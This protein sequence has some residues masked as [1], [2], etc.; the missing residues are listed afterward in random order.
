MTVAYI[1]NGT[2]YN[3]S[4]KNLDRFLQD[5]PNAKKEEDNTADNQI[6]KYYNLE[7]NNWKSYN[8]SAKNLERFKQDYPE[9]RTQQGW[10]DYANEIKTNQ[11]QQKIEDQ[12]IEDDKKKAFEDH[13]NETFKTAFTESGEDFDPSFYNNIE[14]KEKWLKDNDYVL[15]EAGDKAGTY[16]K[17]ETI[18]GAE[19]FLD[20]LGNTLSATG[21]V[22]TKYFGD[23]DATL[24]EAFEEGSE[25]LK[26]YE[27]ETKKEYLLRENPNYLK[28]TDNKISEQIAALNKQK[29]LE[30]DAA[31]IEKIN[32]QIAQ[33]NDS[34]PDIVE[35]S[36]QQVT[37]VQVED[38]DD[39]A[40]ELTNQGVF[41][42]GE[43]NPEI[44]R[45]KFDSL[46]TD[47]SNWPIFEEYVKILQAEQRIFDVAGDMMGGG[48]PEGW[49]EDAAKIAAEFGLNQEDVEKA[50]GS[51]LTF[52]QKGLRGFSLSSVTV[53]DLFKDKREELI[54]QYD[55]SLVDK[56]FEKN[57]WLDDEY[58]KIIYPD[59]TDDDVV[60]IVQGEKLKAKISKA[61]ITQF[62]QF[63][64]IPAIE[65]MTKKRTGLETKE[66]DLQRQEIRNMI[67]QGFMSAVGDDAV[68]RGILDEYVEEAKP[69]L[70]DYKK[71][72]LEQY[73]MTNADDVMKVNRLLEQKQNELTI[74]KMVMDPRYRNR[75]TNIGMAFAEIG[76]E[77][78]VDFTRQQSW[79]Q[80]N[81]DRI[82]DRKDYDWYNPLEFIAEVAEGIGSGVE[83]MSTAIGDQ[84]VASFDGF[85]SREKVKKLDKI[86]EALKQEGVNED[87]YIYFDVWGDAHVVP[88]EDYDDFTDFFT[89]DQ[90]Y[91]LSAE[92]ISDYKKTLNEKKN[93]WDEGISKQMEEAAKSMKRLDAYTSADY[94]DGISLRDIAS[95]VG[96]T[97]PHI[98]VAAAGTIV[99]G[100]AGLP[101]LLAGE[102]SIAATLA[103]YGGTLTMGLQMYG[104]NY[105]SAIEQ[106]LKANKQ[107]RESI[108]EE[109][110]DWTE[111]QVEEQ[112]KQNLI[113]NYKSGEGANI[114]QS[115]AVGAMQ[116]ALES[117]G[118]Q[119]MVTGLQGALKA[120]GMTELTLAS[121]ANA[122]WDDIGKGLYAYAINRGGNALEEFGTE[123][124]QEVLGMMSTG[125]QR[126]E[127]LGTYVN[128]EEALQSGVGGAISGFAI[129]FSGDI[130][131]MSTTAIRQSAAAIAE[132]YGGD[133]KYAQKVKVANAWFNDS[134]AQLDKA[135]DTNEID[136]KKYNESVRALSN[137][138][139]AAIKIGLFGNTGASSTTMSRADKMQLLDLYTDIGTLEQEIEL[140]KDNVPLQNALKEELKVLQSAATDLIIA[141]RVAAK[142]AAADRLAERQQSVGMSILPT[143]TTEDTDS[144]SKIDEM[145]ADEDFD[146]EN[147]LDQKRILK[148]AGG[149]INNAL[150]RLWKPGSLLTRDQFKTALENEYLKT[151]LSYNPEQDTNNQGI[152]QQT[153]NLFN[154]RANKIAKENIRQ[155]GDTISMSDEKAP[156]IGDTTQQQDFDAETQEVRGKR[157]KKYLGSNEK[158]NEA[159]GPEAK[160]EIKNQTSQEILN[161][162][163]K[164]STVSQIKSAINNMFGD[165]KSRGGR[166][167]WKTLGNKIGT[168]TKGY[169]NFVDSVVD[170]E[171]ISQLPAAYIKQSGLGKLLGV[172]KIGKSDKV[173]EKD[174]KKTYSRPDTF[175]LPGEITPEMVQKV[176][177][178]FK[179]DN[180]S[181]IR[182]MQKMSQEFAME[183]L[184][185][186]K[187]DKD[188]M[189]KLQTALGDTQTAKDFMN[190]LESKMDQR[191]VEDSTLDVTTPGKA[192]EQAIDDIVKD[193]N[194]K[195]KDVLDKAIEYFEGLDD[196]FKNT[197]GANPITPFIKAIKLGLKGLR[198]LL[199]QGATL[200]QAIVHAKNVFKNA[201]KYP[202]KL[203]SALGRSARLEMKDLVASKNI[204]LFNPGRKGNINKEQQR[205]RRIGTI[206]SHFL[207]GPEFITSSVLSGSNN[208]LY[209]VISDAEADINSEI[210][211]DMAAELRKQGVPLIELDNGNFKYD[212]RQAAKIDKNGI[213]TKAANEQLGPNSYKTWSPQKI[214][215]KINDPNWRQLQK[216]KLKLL[217]RIAK[218]I[219]TDI[220]ANPQNI[221][222]WASWLTSQSSQSRH[223]I[224][225]LAPIT[226]FNLSKGAPSLFVAEHSLPANN[227]AT[228]IMDMAMRGKVDSEFKLIEKDY[229]QGKLLEA[230]DNKLKTNADKIL[231]SKDM[232]SIYFTGPAMTLNPKTWL[233]YLD[234]IVNDNK[235]GINMNE[236]VTFNND[237]K[238]I[239]VAE[240]FGLPLTKSEYRYGNNKTNFG[241]IKFQNE[242]LYK[243]AAGDMN[244]RQ[245]KSL[246]KTAV[247]SGVK[248][249]E[250][251]MVDNNTD[252]FGSIFRKNVT[253]FSQKKSMLNSLKAR[254]KAL[255][256]NKRPKGLS[257]FDMDDTLAL[258]KEKV[259]Y[260]LNGRKSELTAAE[261]ATQYES[262]LEQGAEFDFSNFDNVDLSTPKGPLAGTALKRQGKYG[263]K[264]IYIV[265]ARPNASQQAIK[266]WA[267]SIGLNIPLENIITL[268]DGSPMAKAEWLLSKAEQGYNDFYFADDSQLN[269]DLVKNI[270]DQIDV[271][272][273][274]QLAIA[275]KANRLDQEMNELIE[276]ATDIGASENV[277]DIEAAIEGKKR[278]KGFFKRILRQFQI[279]A[280]ADDFLGLG[281]KLFGKGEKGTRQQKWFIE[282]LIKPYNKAEQ[283]LISAKIAVANDFAALKKKFPSLSMKGIKKFISNPLTQEV[284]YKSFTKSQAARVYLWNKQGME[285]PGMS[286]TDIDGLVA[287]VEADQE[288]NVFADELQLIQKSEEYPGPTANWI[289]GDIKSDILSGLDKT[290][291]SELLT[292][293]KE[294]RDIIFSD[295][296]MNKLEKAFGSKYVEALRDALKR[297]ETGTNRPTYQ[298]S[299][300]R[301]I[302]EMMDWMNGSVAV[303]MFLNMRS[304]SLQMLS[305]VN[306]I[307]WGDNNIYAAAKAF[308]SKDYVPTVIKLMNSDYLVNRR[309]GLKINVNEAELAAAA[310]RGGFKGMLA[311]LLDKGFVLTRIFDS[312]AIAT[313]GATFYMNRQKSLLNR[314]NEKTGK[315]YTKAEAKQQAFED[316]Y[317]IAEETQQSSNPSKISSQQASLFGR[318]ILSFQNVTMQY[319]RKAKKMLLDLINRRRRPGM[320]QRESDLSNLSGVIYYVGVQNLVFNSLQQA[321]FAVAFEDEEEKDRNK[322][323][324]TINGMVDSI[325]FGLG[326]GGALISTVKN[327]IRELD[328]QAGKKT[329][330]YEE[331]LF[332][333]FDI[334]PVIDTKV[335]NIRNGLRTFSWN[336]ADIKKRGWSLDNPAYIAI[337]S[338]ISG[339]TNIPIDRLFR[340]INNIR[341]ATDE[342][343]RTFERVALLL[344]WNGWNFGLP[345]WGRESTI[346]REE[347][348]E[349]RLKKRFKAQVEYAKSKGFTKRV[350]FTGKNSWSNGIP[351]G[352]KENVDYIAI[353][354]YDGIIQYYKKP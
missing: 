115:A 177:D 213:I 156:Q 196:D 157:D 263:A 45:Q 340:K 329:P 39:A 258:T 248:V 125:L 50:M 220:K 233:R 112:Y 297:M 114:A 308:L 76:R 8:V 116:A 349:E 64:D 174:G 201:L 282:N 310:N 28:D 87:D 334:S 42:E 230:D 332:N 17:K 135:L 74:G 194:F 319:N 75:S 257:A 290:L 124:M 214:L 11:E 293:W 40:K 244:I 102:A 341:Q 111:E 205:Q 6:T 237:G 190:D 278:D 91:G 276:D 287:A 70:D 342:N 20:M 161:Q 351:K 106:N 271:K 227:V 84:T 148:E 335:R 266:L 295:K 167:L 269:V 202:A 180:P 27:E 225:S 223:P 323:A 232:P 142:Q 337:S 41:F 58:V 96:N 231:L 13:V 317:D 43:F 291:R 32:N 67:D 105:H 243:V 155:Q 37:E 101:A 272:S 256:I 62:K 152:G 35:F 315:K 350:P 339:A 30:T 24:M 183:S 51:S 181:R 250:Q 321:L 259:I 98:G 344:G 352:L 252:T 68:I 198:K 141:D 5:H 160:N 34:R 22:I 264:D 123:Y 292:E 2:R 31:E 136:Q 246:L 94:S 69:V 54:K 325:L 7:N 89:G 120:A 170:A 19:K 207:L 222:Y 218:I 36:L 203:Y 273:R 210:D 166:G 103:A 78:D 189:Q 277:S 52:G 208:S 229:F 353:E 100:G 242:L 61:A 108:R 268:E 4:E 79:F 95:T 314:I 56:G 354:R 247:E 260:T 146:P 312:L 179:K 48:Q 1:S 9:A 14:D 137:V 333:L 132:R 212:Q 239:S 345:Y 328:Y 16:Q 15:V 118:A 302:N 245:A 53:D 255:K 138:R 241:I 90:I 330:E 153:S 163:N 311:Y 215:Q 306:F 158:V 261:F 348:E 49:K 172:E 289:A 346:K 129:P 169:K 251:Q 305:N 184:Q 274:V 234:T 134:K 93:Y 73:D 80:R 192:G 71:Q 65:Q 38:L 151:F 10:E 281:Y 59:A 82:Y 204:K 199:K 338:I 25:K 324:D 12:K 304:G 200:K 21:D 197:L 143:Q 81:M 147:R 238:I 92:K 318:L 23:E 296:N 66:E 57:T 113:N 236:L 119:Q 109:H 331:A 164:G 126:G 300:S 299:Y 171:F 217:K 182:L 326:F 130:K 206:V 46:N 133:S 265:T 150:N 63:L 270:L 347:A 26:S 85:M 107:D 288:L 44:I 72:L 186:L 175:L 313:G 301:G 254:I 29:K 228:M 128:W 285:I 280:S 240:K 104:D 307:N 336:M 88:A 303:A 47:E 195:D 279:T 127:N 159:V 99:S 224:R 235:G 262:L 193:E 97:L 191:T 283:E 343:V 60:E 122:T 219:E 298:G 216:D 188:F 249:A 139:N 149:T 185:E 110:P 327:V 309:D 178:Y 165:A 187:A 221:A 253:P 33:L 144:Y 77:Y 211:A 154:L 145:Y 117:Y 131:T 226:F 162:A 267:D 275:D 176:K 3:V 209:N 55:K 286:Q 320:T 173:I 284:G 322:T 168:M 86:E 83:G 140:A 121:I 294:N 316:F 18:G